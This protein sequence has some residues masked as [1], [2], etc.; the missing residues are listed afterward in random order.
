MN[1]CQSTTVSFEK[2]GHIIG[3]WQ[4]IQINKISSLSDQFMQTD[5]NSHKYGVS[6][7]VV[8]KTAQIVSPVKD[9]QTLVMEGHG[10]SLL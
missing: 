4:T 7:H 2:N 3:V 6:F 5:E 9:R 10:V 1:Y 8:M